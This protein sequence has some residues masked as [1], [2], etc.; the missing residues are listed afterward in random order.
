MNKTAFYQEIYQKP[1]R[2]SDKDLGWI[3]AIMVALTAIVI[4]LK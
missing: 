4:L 1:T 3:L 2:R